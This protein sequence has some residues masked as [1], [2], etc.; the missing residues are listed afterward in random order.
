MK[1]NE[2]IMKQVRFA[3]LRRLDVKPASTL[4]EDLPVLALVAAIVAAMLVFT[5]FFLLGVG[6]AILWLQVW[7]LI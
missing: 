6:A 2:E 4:R 5:Y 7:G 3:E 1:M